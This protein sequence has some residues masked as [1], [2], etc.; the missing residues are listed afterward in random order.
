VVVARVGVG[1]VGDRP[2]LVPEAGAALV[3]DAI[4]AGVADAAG[5]AAAAAID[6]PLEDIHGS[7]RYRRRL[8]EVL[9]AR[10]ARTAFQRA[11]EATA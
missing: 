7:A 4:D 1:A 8:V 5:R 2:L 10:T 11:R 3:G 6:A 9:V